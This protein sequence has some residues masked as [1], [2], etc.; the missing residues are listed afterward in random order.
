M[1]KRKRMR[2]PNGFGQITEIKGRNLRKPFRAMI[3]VGKTDKGKPICKPLK[4]TAYFETYNDAYK[5]LVE[6]HQN[7]YNLSSKISLKELYERW[8][9]EYYVKYKSDTAIRTMTSAWAYCSELYD[10]PVA[11]LRARHLKGCIE[12]ATAVFDGKVREASSGTKSRMK[13]L[14]NLMFDY[15]VEYEI[16]DKNWARTFTIEEDRVRP[17]SSNKHTDFSDEEMK[18]LW[19]NQNIFIVDMILIQC[20]TGFRPGELAELLVENVNLEAGT[21]VGGFKTEAGTDRTVPIHSKIRKLVEA[22]YKDATERG[23]KYLFNYTIGTRQTENFTYDRYRHKF[24]KAL[25]MIGITKE[26]RAHD[27][28]VQFVTMA[29]KANMDEYAIKYIVGHAILDLTESVYTRRNVEWL[30]TEIEKIK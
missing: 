14:F 19:A 28:R 29:K 30:S 12:N 16:I 26:H 24:V 4:P 18:T 27:P 15:A 3:T 21:I 5:A 22:R 20:Y 8:S 25:T 6:Y 17:A 2:L 1:Q 9:E 11:S 7:P 13:S 23:S 10:V